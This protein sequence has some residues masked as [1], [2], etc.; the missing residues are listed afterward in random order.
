VLQPTST[1]A[2]NEVWFI[3]DLPSH[4]YQFSSTTNHLSH[5]SNGAIRDLLPIG[6]V[7]WECGHD[8]FSY[9]EWD[10]LGATRFLELRWF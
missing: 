5:D 9:L 6:L 3:T 10:I 4:S 1:D 2:T 8:F 7:V